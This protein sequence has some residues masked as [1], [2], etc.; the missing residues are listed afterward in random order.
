MKGIVQAALI[1][2]VAVLAPI[3]TVLITTGVLVTADLI[4]GLIAARRR[5]DKI[6][7]SGLRRTVTKTLVYQ[8][9]I[10]LGFLTETYLMAG[11]LPVAKLIAGMIGTVELKSILENLDDINGSPLF[12]SII[13][14]LGSSNDQIKK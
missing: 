1:S 10:I 11:V 13:S 2:L 5:G 8:I 14:K 4:I 7:S 12:T 6:V 9:A 3:K